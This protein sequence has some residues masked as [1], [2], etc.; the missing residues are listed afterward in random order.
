[1]VSNFSIKIPVTKFTWSDL[2][3]E[4]MLVE[5]EAISQAVDEKKAELAQRGSMA[6]LADLK[7]VDLAH[8]L[9]L[10]EKL[11]QWCSYAVTWLQPDLKLSELLNHEELLRN[12]V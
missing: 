10:D 12:Q 2:G 8:Q 4:Q 7:V 1:M 9:P 3:L 6:D 11:W 5:T